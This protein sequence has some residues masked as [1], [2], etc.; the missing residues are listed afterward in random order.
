MDPAAL[1]QTLRRVV[2]AARLVKERHLKRLLSRLA[3]ND[4]AMPES[5]PY[6]VDRERVAGYGVLPETVTAG[7]DPRLL[8]IV[9]PADR[10]PHGTAESA[11]LFHCW[12][13]LYRGMVVEQ[14]RTPN[15][16]RWADL[17]A[18]VRVE[19]EF[20]LVA[21]RLIPAAASDAEKYAA[22]AAQFLALY[23]FAP[24]TLR[25]W[26]PSADRDRVLVCL[27][28]DLDDARLYHST[29]PEGA[30]DRRPISSPTILEPER[31]GEPVRGGL[32]TAR[33]DR[34]SL[35]RNHVRAAVLRTK[36]ANSL[37]SG[38]TKHRKA[39][40]EEIGGRL[41]PRLAGV[42][43][44]DEMTQRAWTNALVPLLDSAA[45][46]YWSLAARALYDLQKVAVDLEGDLYEADPAGWVRSFGARPLVRKLTL[47]RRS[48]LLRHLVSA[49][50]HLHRAALPEVVRSRLYP[51][52][53]GE[54]ERT[55]RALRADVEPII[56]RVLDEVGLVP[57][58]VPET[59]GRDKLVAE[60]LDTICE[61]GH[62][63]LADLRDAIARNRL[64]LPDLAGPVEFVRGD[65][66]LRADAK[67]GDALDGI[68]HRGEVYLRWIQRGSATAF[69]TATGRFLTK[70]VAIPV[71]GAVMTVEFA[72]YVVME[73]GMLYGWVSGL[74]SHQPT[75]EAAKETHEHGHGP[76]FTPESITAMAVLAVLYLGLMHSS[77]CRSAVWNGLKWVSRG[78]KAVFVTGPLWVWRT[79]LVRTLRN[80][81][82]R[83]FV[84]R[85]F[86]WPI[87]AG[88]WVALFLLLFG[89]SSE[90]ILRWGVGTFLVLTVMLNLPVGR[91]WK[92]HFEEFLS[93]AWRSLRV[94]LLPGLFTFLVWLFRELLGAVDR[95]LYTVDEWFRFRE[96]QSKPSTVLKAVLGLVWF[97]LAYV[98]R[99]AFYLLIE[100]QVNPLKHFPVVT[101]SHK[102]LLPMIPGVSKLTGVSEWTVGA[103]FTGIPGIFGFIVWELKENWRLYAANRPERLGPLALGHHGET[104]RGFLR[105]GFHSGTV[106]AAFAK[107]RAAVAK[108][109]R[110]GV[111]PVTEKYED[112]LHHVEHAVEAF[113]ER[114]LLA[115]VRTT[116]AWRGVTVEVAAVHLG[117]QRVA[118]EVRAPGVAAE[119]AGVVFTRQWDQILMAVSP[120][121]FVEQLNPAQR[122]VWDRAVAGLAAM[123]AASAVGPAWGEWVEFWGSRK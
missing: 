70:F 38:G 110:R 90:R 35:V 116:T 80:N 7:D 119:P 45:T 16:N 83:R 41:V 85:Y 88:A 21:E 32:A 57:A 23:R 97:P 3:D 78:L 42:F 31:N 44:W 52:L 33:A 106:P 73:V 76:I 27:R 49:R 123:G 43:G 68:H 91:R 8:L 18:D 92:D 100:P 104:M 84:H 2:P 55:E 22:F 14:F 72:K 114:E 9:E 26:F 37:P 109:D 4:A 50:K 5:G 51:L 11:V 122:G 48:I 34:A 86:G 15:A 6:W 99:F 62:T 81:R 103:V 59:V 87:A 117:L 82:A 98:V 39:A 60:L 63:R 96:G 71:G 113:V 54:I 75:G 105:P 64:K 29:R 10:L 47:S 93:D 107:A 20:V 120:L 79:S 102:L 25:F 40:K 12:R 69:G 30:T 89:A 65:A 67:L 112:T 61:H 36:L 74:V 94:D 118:C 58:T 108:A 19:A 66:L 13:E 28:K 95:G 17:D 115:S 53:D 1:E 77:A 101:V 121:G 24:D 111:P 56:R 46:G